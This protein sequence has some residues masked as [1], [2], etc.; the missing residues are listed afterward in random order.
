MRKNKTSGIY[1]IENIKTHKKQI[2]QSVDIDSRWNSHV[3]ELKRGVHHNDYLQKSW[4]KYGKDYFKFYILEYCEKDK[5]DEREIYY[6]NFYQTMDRKYGYNLK[7]GGQASNSLSNET[8]EKLSKAIKETYLNP[9]R[10]QIQS[11]NALKQWSDPDI[12]EKISGKNNGMYGKH[13]TEES[14]QKMREKR[15]GKPSP[16]RDKT[17]VICVEL[18]KV[19]EDAVIAAEYMG[20]KRSSTG[21]LLSVCRGERKTCGGYHWKFYL[22]NNIS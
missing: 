1:C 20:I 14:K 21:S 6:I 7:T 4:D 5:L 15:I 18:N 9:E 17:P 12:K 3:N 13:H 16:M 8:K 19:F 10:K 22:E 2:G 11:T